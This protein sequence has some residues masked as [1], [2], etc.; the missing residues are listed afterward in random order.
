M[1][2]KKALYGLKDSPGVWQ[3]YLAEELV[4]LGGDRFKSDG[5][6]CYFDE[7]IRRRL[8]DT[9]PTTTIATRT[10]TE[11]VT[12]KTLQELTPGTTG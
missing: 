8:D 2:T 9:R 7:Y 10:S 5:N 6:V 12:V 1:E 11:K 4:K 3:Y